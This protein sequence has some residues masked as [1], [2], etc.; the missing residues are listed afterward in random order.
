M[1]SDEHLEVVVDAVARLEPVDAVFLSRR[2]VESS[3]QLQW[4]DVPAALEEGRQ[5][6]CLRHDDGDPPRWWLS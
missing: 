5:L 1:V 3:T 4:L 2:L 6:G